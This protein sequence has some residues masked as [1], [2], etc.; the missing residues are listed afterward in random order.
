MPPSS[1]RAVLGDDELLVDP[2]HRVGEDQLEGALGGRERV[3]EG[4]HVDAEQL[5]LGRHVGAGERA[6]PAEQRVDD[7]LGHR[8]AG[9]H[10]AVHPAAGGGALADGPDV[11][12]G[13]AALLVDQ[14]AAALGEVEPGGPGQGVARADAGGEDDDLGRDRLVR[15]SG[16]SPVTRPSSPSTSV[17]HRA[18]VHAAG[19]APRRGGAAWRRR[20]RRPAPAISRGAISTTWVSRPSWASALA[21]SRPSSPPPTTAPTRAPPRRRPGS[22]RGPRW[23]GRRSSRRRSWPGSAARRARP[24]WRAPARRRAAPRRRRARPCARSGSIAVDLGAERRSR[25][26]GSSYAPVGQ[27]ARAPRRRPRRTT[28]A[29][30]GRTPARGSSPT[31]HDVVGLGQAALDRGLDEPVADHAVADDDEGLAAGGPSRCGSF[32]VGGGASGW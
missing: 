23:C 4:G 6:G 16:A 13:G 29:R 24:R 31:H 3:A 27:A 28:S 2:G 19:R 9:R 21:A 7:D 26:R 20:R 32:R 10:Q 1:C 12:V 8:V 18:G 11:R 15:P 5:Q 14:H 30:P 22:P 25:T 17:G